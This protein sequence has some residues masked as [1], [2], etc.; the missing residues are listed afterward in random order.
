MKET[1]ESLIVRYLCSAICF[2]LMGLF[3]CVSLIDGQLNFGNNL[4]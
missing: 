1:T 2:S 4:I 3:Q